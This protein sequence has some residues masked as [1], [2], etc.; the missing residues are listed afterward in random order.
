MGRSYFIRM[1]SYKPNL[2]LLSCQRGVTLVSRSAACSLLL[3]LFPFILYTWSFESK[4]YIGSETAHVGIANDQDDATHKK[5][6]QF[7]WWH[8]CR[9]QVDSK[10]FLCVAADILLICQLGIMEKLVLHVCCEH[11]WL[12]AFNNHNQQSSFFSELAKHVGQRRWSGQAQHRQG[13]LGHCG[14][15]SSGRHQLSQWPGLTQSG[16]ISSDTATLYHV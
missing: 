4:S 9:H 14:W 15:S 8:F 10:P 3:F 7:S 16:A 6:Q 12:R 1:S 5:N 13:L 11:F 2:A